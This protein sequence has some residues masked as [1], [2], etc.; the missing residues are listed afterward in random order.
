M[1]N[2]YI[3]I[4][5][6]NYPQ[7]FRLVKQLDYPKNDIYVHINADVELPDFSKM[8]AAMWHS[9]I[10]EIPRNKMCWGTYGLLRA[11]LTG[12]RVAT[13]QNQYDYYHV[14]SGVDI[15]LK[16]NMYIND[17]LQKN[18]Y[19]N[20]SCGILK[21]NY[22]YIDKGFKPRDIAFVAHYNL[23]VPLWRDSNI[24]VRKISR[25]I[26]SMGY[27][28]QQFLHV[29]RLK[30]DLSYDRIAKGSS[31]W[32]ITDELAE[33]IL[34]KQQWIEEKFSRYTFA[35]DET[36]IQTLIFNSKFFSSLYNYGEGEN[37]NMRCIDWKRGRPYVFRTND[38]NTLINSK[39]LFARKVDEKIDQEIIE[40]IYMNLER[41]EK[42]EHEL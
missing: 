21:T 17:F 8:R 12:L 27:Y 16:T 5:H 33:F 11:M 26:N 38:Y 3:I 4:A 10:Y 31:W 7:L 30:C 20:N 28:V 15:P 14:L 22:V 18:L 1:K 37:Q 41:E 13:E 24:V 36:A 39:Y 29:N 6:D 23:L 32:S 34:S 35:A 19:N 25:M 42:E 40:K 9:S 2:A